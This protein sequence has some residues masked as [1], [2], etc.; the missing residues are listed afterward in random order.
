[1]QTIDSDSL[2][3]SLS[4]GLNDIVA[5]DNISPRTTP[6][7]NNGALF[8]PETFKSP[9]FKALNNSSSGGS[10]TSSLDIIGVFNISNA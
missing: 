8:D 9:L 6:Q 7:S 2:P 4:Q 10:K 1:M 3:L 5:C